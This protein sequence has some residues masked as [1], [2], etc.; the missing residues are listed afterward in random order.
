M[1]KVISILLVTGLSLSSWGAVYARKASGNWSTLTQWQDN[2]TGSYITSTV[3]PG[4]SDTAVIN[5]SMIVAL[6]TDATVSLCQIVNNANSGMLN[7]SSTNMLTV[8]SLQVGANST[9]TGTLNQTAGTVFAATTTVGRATGAPGTYNLTGGTFNMNGTLTINS[10]GLFDL[11][12]GVLSNSYSGANRTIGGTGIF[13]MSSGAIIINGTPAT[14][15]FIVSVATFD[16]TGG[17]IVTE[18]QFQLGTATASAVFNLGGTGRVFADSFSALSSS[19]MNFQGTNSALYLGGQNQRS[20]I[21]AA[22]A[23]GRI[24]IDGTNVLDSSFFVYENVNVA[25]KDWTK[26]TVFNPTT[27]QLPPVDATTLNGKVLCGYQ[28]WFT[29]AGDYGSN[30]RWIHWARNHAMPAGTNLTIE[31]YPDL[32]EYADDELFATTMTKG[33]QP[34]MLYSGTRYKTVRRH[35]RWMQEYGI[36]GAFVQRFVVTQA[37]A[38][39]S[40]KN[41]MLNALKN[42]QTGCE[43][44]GRVFAVMYDVSAM[45][46]TSSWWSVITNDWTML[47]DSGIVGS[48]RY[49]KHNGKPVV[50][51]W[52]FG[53]KTDPHGPDDPAVALAS[54]NWFKTGAPAQYRATVFGGVPGQWR[55]RD[56]DS[57]TAS[58][59]TGVYHAFDVVSPWTVGRYNSNSGADTWK[60]SRIVPDI[61]DTQSAGIG[62]CP[63]IWPGFS[64]YNLNAGPKNEIKRDGG[65]FYWRQ[66]HNAISAGATNMIY[67]AM[68]DEV[69]EATAIYKTAPTAAQTPD[70]GYWLTLDADGY[71]LPSDWYLRLAFETGRMLRKETAL[72][73]TRPSNPGPFSTVH[74]TALSWLNTHQL[75]TDGAEVADAEDP[76]GDG[77]KTW[78]EYLAGTD[79]T[80]AAS[81]FRMTGISFSNGA[82]VV[83]WYGTA[84]GSAAPWSMYVST[85]LSG[86]W[87]LAASNSIPRNPVNGTNRWVDS[88]ATNKQIRFY[89]P[90]VF[91]P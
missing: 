38:D 21:T 72:T 85:N 68:F 65:N 43:E 70:Q 39:T 25:G 11:N 35:V 32:S 41:H 83:S 82:A 13:R 16:M 69:D 8:S 20:A 12:G 58:G 89:R 60:T 46:A 45:A 81:L 5:N 79:P 37:G 75:I 3:L 53:F 57:F 52:G 24:Q 47:V 19:K 27:V 15:L 55:T 80:N 62:Y 1:K 14:N 84:G 31:M 6:N 56:G 36:D 78:Q 87:T 9:G 17:E 59:W 29:A 71:S 74:G 54:I 77:F 4:S 42:F 44:Y 10:T 66:A 67:I 30:T 63:V 50:G 61:A 49:L 28:A 51:I 90:A 88:S 34:A 73:A 26:I 23:S 40:Y 48:D 91:G 86:G 76:D 18:K 33:G 2:A 7:V 22:A 64:W